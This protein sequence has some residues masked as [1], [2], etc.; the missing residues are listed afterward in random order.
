VTPVEIVASPVVHAPAAAAI[1]GTGFV[2]D[3]NV[4]HVFALRRDA[5]GFSSGDAPAPARLDL[6]GS[7][8]DG[9]V[10][11]AIVSAGSDGVAV[12]AVAPDTPVETVGRALDRITSLR[13]RSYDR[14]VDG[15]TGMFRTVVLTPAL[16]TFE[17]LRAHR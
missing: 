3:G 13:V 12:L 15:A 11:N 16:T 4:L 1:R 8:G 10:I 7:Q 5:A 14:R 6:Q 17:A 9:D 2:L